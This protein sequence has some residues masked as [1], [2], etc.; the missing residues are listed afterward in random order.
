VSATALLFSRADSRVRQ[1]F[2]ARIPIWIALQPRSD[3]NWIPC[4]RTLFLDYPNV[5]VGLEFSPDSKLLAVYAHKS[6]SLQIL[7]VNT[8]NCLHTIK[9]DLRD[10][11]SA[12]FM[13]KVMDLRFSPDSKLLYLAWVDHVIMC[14][15]DT[16]QI[17]RKFNHN[18]SRLLFET[19]ISSSHACFGSDGEDDHVWQANTGPL[20]SQLGKQEDS[21]SSLSF[22]TCLRYLVS[23]SQRGTVSIWRMGSWKLIKQFEVPN[24]G[25]CE[26]VAL[27]DKPARVAF[28]TDIQIIIWDLT[29]DKASHTL[30]LSEQFRCMEYLINSGLIF[31]TGNSLQAFEPN[32]A[33]I[34]R[35]PNTDAIDAIKSGGPDTMATLSLDIAA[36]DV[37]RLDTGHHLKRIDI[38]LTTSPV[39]MALSVDG[40]LLASGDG[41]ERIRIWNA[42][43]NEKQE[44]NVHP[45]TRLQLSPDSLMVS[46]VSSAPCQSTVTFWSTET[47]KQLN[48]VQINSMGFISEY[49][50]LLEFSPDSRLLLVVCMSDIH[51]LEAK[52]GHLM[53]T[54]KAPIGKFHIAAVFSCSSDLIASICSQHKHSFQSFTQIWQVNTGRCV[55]TLKGSENGDLFV[56]FV[57]DSS[58]LITQD[59]KSAL[60]LWD[61]STGQCVFKIQAQWTRGARLMLAAYASN[62]RLLAVASEH[63]K[64][65][66]IWL[67]CIDIRRCDTGN[68]LKRVVLGGVPCCLRFGDKESPVLTSYNGLFDI[69]S[70]TPE[71][72]G[73]ETSNEIFEP[74][75][76]ISECSIFWKEHRLVQLP[77]NTDWRRVHIHGPLIV[78]ASTQGHVTIM[79]LDLLKLDEMHKGTLSCQRPSLRCLYT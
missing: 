31:A 35:W 11:S 60:R 16:G 66:D 55:L 62:S 56:S 43:D 72:S 29:A 52:T 8:G 34:K 77:S 75:L 47:G 23:A 2:H 25:S 18:Q 19:S 5:V 1:I 39:S 73:V 69:Q 48:R 3:L 7:Q 65:Q 27:M 32:T 38:N 42:A 21:I 78:F 14:C 57:Q 44:S 63:R 26:Q 64:E 54:L 10:M 37:W 13:R 74:T 22:S 41:S 53:R 45:V 61:I 17:I 9:C 20:I 33:S 68:L 24:D 70:L 30:K 36:I 6:S 67:W 15:V 40:R 46:S 50:R 49:Q 58:F 79:R 59:S 28:A 12:R 51:I 4:I 76:S 71:T